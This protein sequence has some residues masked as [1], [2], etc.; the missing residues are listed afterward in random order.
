MAIGENLS[1]GKKPVT[2]FEEVRLG[3]RGTAK[4]IP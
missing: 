2:D 4:E 3:R 1:R